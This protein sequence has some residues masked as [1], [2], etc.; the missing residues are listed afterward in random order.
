MRN[1]ENGK[2]A[3]PPASSRVRPASSRV[4]QAP[5]GSGS[6]RPASSKAQQGPA[7]PGEAKNP[8]KSRK[9]PENVPDPRNQLFPTF[10]KNVGDHFLGPWGPLGAPGPPPRASWGPGPRAHGALGPGP[11][12]ARVCPWRPPVGGRPW[13]QEIGEE[14]LGKPDFR[15]NF[16]RCVFDLI[17]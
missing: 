11:M 7:R 17:F 9:I 14:K 2:D 6:L 12:Y 16:P 8:G 1:L 4:R 10:S 5:A 13:A 15:D 3:Q